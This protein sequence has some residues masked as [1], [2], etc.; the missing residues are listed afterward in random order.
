[1]FAG[2]ALAAL[3]IALLVS[4]L[5][6][7]WVRSVNGAPPNHPY[8]F[9][10]FWTIC[11]FLAIY[12]FSLFEGARGG[13]SRTNEK[14]LSFWAH[15]RFGNFMGAAFG[16]AVADLPLTLLLIAILG[17]L[18]GP[19]IPSLA[20]YWSR[21][22]PVFCIT[23]IGA[24][25]YELSHAGKKWEQAK[26]LEKRD[27]LEPARRDEA[28]ILR[29]KR[30]ERSKLPYGRHGFDDGSAYHFVFSAVLANTRRSVSNCALPA[31]EG[32]ALLKQLEGLELLDG[33]LGMLL[34]DL[35]DYESWQYDREAAEQSF[36]IGLTWSQRRDGEG[37]VTG[38]AAQFPRGGRMFGI[39]WSYGDRRTQFEIFSDGQ[40][41]M[42]CGTY[43]SGRNDEGYEYGPFLFGGVS[44]FINGDWVEILRNFARECRAATP[45]FILLRDELRERKRLEA[46][47]ESFGL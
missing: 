5:N 17:A 14:S 24:F 18:A 35:K 34:F 23:S 29:K 22:V 6:G 13:A 39:E 38:V 42:V 2:L 4:G 8:G 28:E 26:V 44:R 37:N 11:P 15:F 40:S 21:Y 1:V 10:Y 7:E 31:V 43:G 32:A 25:L 27:D 33:F 12:G 9:Y 3:P 36:P 41:V 19:G 30:E 20:D 16:L 46:L 45:R 47:K